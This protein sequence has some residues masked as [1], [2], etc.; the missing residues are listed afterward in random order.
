MAEEKK[1]PSWFG[2]LIN[3]FKCLPGRIATAFK[4]MVAELRVVAWPSRKKLISSTVTVLLFMLFMG[5]VVGLLDSGSFTAIN[6]LS[7]VFTPKAA[8]T[9]PAEGTETPVE[10]VETPVEGAQVPAEGAEAPAEGAEA[11]VEGV[12]APVEGAEV[13]AETNEAPAE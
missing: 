12:E 13:P 4:N 2:K 6:A 7:D 1:N 10:G 5:V 9:V 8:V 3:W 11:P